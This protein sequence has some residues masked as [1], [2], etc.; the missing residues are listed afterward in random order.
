M[1]YVNGPKWRTCVKKIRAVPQPSGIL[2]VGEPLTDVAFRCLED[3]ITTRKLPPGSMVSEVQLA[4]E[5]KMGRTPIREALQRLR[6][7]GFVEMHARRGTFVCGVDVQ[8]QLE[9]L[10]VRRP[11]EELVV[12]SAAFRATQA[13][14][15]ELPK[16]A[17]RMM[18]AAQRESID[19]YIYAGREV[20]EAEVRATH[21][22]MLVAT[23]QAIHAQSRRFYWSMAQV[24]TYQEGA[25]HHKK[26]LTAIA[27]R[28]A[29][30]AVEAVRG[31]MQFL[32]EV[33]RATLDTYST[34]R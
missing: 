4:S 10:E 22:A 26:V 6:Q 9:L 18:E 30:T 11:L 12:R 29:T 5:L 1:C 15:E 13:E 34:G 31:L 23:M 32:E 8:Q 17:D 7:I 19:D 3:M 33:T 21:N 20:H 2:A 27:A 28:E 24:R 25:A 14:R 16:L